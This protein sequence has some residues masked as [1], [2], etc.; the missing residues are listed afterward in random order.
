MVSHF[1]PEVRKERAHVFLEVARKSPDGLLVGCCRQAPM[2]LYEP[3]MV[4]A[5]K[6]ETG[7]DPQAI[8][9]PNHD[10]Y[11]RWIKWRADHFTQVLRDL[12]QGLKPTEQEQGR[13]LPVAVRIPSSGFLYNLAQGLDVEQWVAEGLADQIQWDPLETWGGRWSHDV[14]PDVELGRKHGVTIIGGIGATGPPSRQWQ[15]VF[16]GLWGWPMR[17]WTASRSTRPSCSPRPA[18]GAGPY[19]FL[20]IPTAP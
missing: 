13:R 5:F 7:I 10:D 1:F 19:P 6:A 16:A 4:A 8:D 20:A 15:R 18:T 14:R 9:A 2:L 17:E 11:L 12:R 3:E